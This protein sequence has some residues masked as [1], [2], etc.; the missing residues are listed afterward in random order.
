M[1]VSAKKGQGPKAEEL[2]RDAISQTKKD[3]LRGPHR[4]APREELWSGGELVGPNPACRFG[5]QQ[6]DEL[7][8]VDDLRWSSTNEATLARTPINLLHG[9]T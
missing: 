6:V 5:V 4:F 3:W 7:R 8:A 2:W 1:F 9:T